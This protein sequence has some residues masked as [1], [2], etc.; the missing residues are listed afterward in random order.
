MLASS[1]E[2]GESRAQDEERACSF[3]YVIVRVVPRVEREEFLNAGV[4][5]F[6]S[7]RSFLEA[8]VELD[9]AR[10]QVLAPH[11]EPELIWEHLQAIP[12]VCAGGRSAGFIGSLRQR[13]RFHWLAAPRST[14]I[15]TSPMHSG[16]SHDP[17][18]ALERLF[19]TLVRLPS[20]A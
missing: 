3:D 17:K 5:V 13:E 15:Q 2:S 12:L 7:Q 8:R 20:R 11:A 4:I 1:F 14:I 19:E 9:R 6:C 16:L 10:L 18:L